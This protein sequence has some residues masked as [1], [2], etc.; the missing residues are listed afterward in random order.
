MPTAA[1]HMVD[2]TSPW[3]PPDRHHLMPP[4]PPA[5]A[6][7]LHHHRRV[8]KRRPRPS[9]RQPTTYISADPAN[10]RRMVHQFTG[11]D[12]LPPPPPALSPPTELVRPVRA[13]LM[14]PTLDTS[15]FLLGGEALVVPRTEAAVATS[16]WRW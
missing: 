3:L 14:L 6:G 10:F 8:A 5:I 15:A 2:S 4:P 9:R 7:T 13:P 1:V 12:D 16:R 11:A